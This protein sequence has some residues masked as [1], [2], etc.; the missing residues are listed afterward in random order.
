MNHADLQAPSPFLRRE[1]PRGPLEPEQLLV[2]LQFKGIA[3]NEEWE[4]VANYILDTWPALRV[5]WLADSVRMLGS[6]GLG[7]FMERPREY[8][9]AL[10]SFWGGGP[11]CFLLTLDCRSRDHVCFKDVYLFG[12]WR[13]ILLADHVW[14]PRGI[15]HSLEPCIQGQ[16]VLVY[17][18]VVVYTRNDGSNDFGIEPIKAFR[19]ST[20]PIAK[21]QNREP[22]AVGREALCVQGPGV[23]GQ[24]LEMAE[25]AA[26]S[27]V[28]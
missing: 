3:R 28:K 4:I 18:P 2:V 23:N 5:A 1:M 8:R 25:R 7:D 22:S 19:L 20:A 27:T 15:L 6:R 11:Q 12:N 13:E 21:I 9:F 24:R 17:G 10:G 26:V 16:K 14:L